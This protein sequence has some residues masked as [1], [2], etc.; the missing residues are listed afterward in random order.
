M[1]FKYCLIHITIIMLRDILYLVYLCLC[2]GL[3]LFMSHLCDLCF[4]FS[5]IFIIINHIQGRRHRGVRGGRGCHGPPLFGIAKRKK[6]GFSK[7]KLL[8]GCHQGLNVTV[9]AILE[10]LEFK[11][12]SCQ[13]TMVADNTFQCS[14]APTL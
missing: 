11:K 6:E 12:F 1:S 5:F 7:Q 8:K 10:C 2:L 13:S 4:I 14:M 3:G 9:L